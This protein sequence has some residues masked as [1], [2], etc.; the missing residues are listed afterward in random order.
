ML[1]QGIVIL[2]NTALASPPFVG[3][4]YEVLPKGAGLPNWTYR[5]ISDIP[6]TTL[7]SAKGL[8]MRRLQI[9]VY[10]GGGATQANLGSDAIDLASSI[11]NILNG[12]AGI[13]PDTG[14]TFVS[15]CFRSDIDDFYD[16][17]NRSWRRMLEYEIQYA[18]S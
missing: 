3:G 14:A 10:G 7:Q 2:V 18:Q 11:D 12:Y 17:V 1:E 6:N 16:S 8:A 4:Y 13:L 5:T 15:S 9:D